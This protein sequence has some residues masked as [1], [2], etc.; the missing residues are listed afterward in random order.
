MPLIKD[1]CKTGCMERSHSIL[2]RKINLGKLSS[3]DLLSHYMLVYSLLKWVIMY[4]E[5]YFVEGFR[6]CP[7]SSL[8]SKLEHSVQ[9]ERVRRAGGGEEI[10]RCKSGTTG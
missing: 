3:S 2:E 4:I 1:E 10:G 5:S 6:Q 7:C 9:N 8:P